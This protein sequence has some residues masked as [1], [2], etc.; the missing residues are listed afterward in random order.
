LY[1]NCVGSGEAG[2]YGCSRNIEEKEGR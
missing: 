2:P 1:V